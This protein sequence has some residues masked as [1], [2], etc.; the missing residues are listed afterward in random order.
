MSKGHH[1]ESGSAVSNWFCPGSLRRAGQATPRS[2]AGEAVGSAAA[3]REVPL[4]GR[5]LRPSG[6]LAT[7]SALSPPKHLLPALAQMSAFPGVKAHASP[8][9][10]CVFVGR[11]LPVIS[12]GNLLCPPQSPREHWR[13]CTDIVAMWVEEM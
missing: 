9:P 1:R 8:R 5:E 7:A 11:V 2:R 10:F 13:V 12:L 6:L 4:P 3:L